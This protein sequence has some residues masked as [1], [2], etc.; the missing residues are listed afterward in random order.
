MRAKIEANSG[1]DALQRGA[2]C[3][4]SM[5][6]TLARMTPE[7]AEI[8]ELMALSIAGYRTSD[9]SSPA[10][11]VWRKA[12]LNLLQRKPLS[13]SQD[14]RTA[15][16]VALLHFM[17]ALDREAAVS[18]LLKDASLSLGDRVAF[19]CRCLPRK[20]L[21]GFLQRSMEE[22]MEDGKAARCLMLIGLTLRAKR[23]SA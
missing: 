1:V 2:D 10:S 20:D 15:Y 5:A 4:R 13:S 12:C 18:E 17:T 22:C 6:S 9:T 21:N 14:S 11:S 3:I 8:L 16:L 23:R 7:Y 19:A